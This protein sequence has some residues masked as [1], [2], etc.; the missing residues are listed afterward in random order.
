MWR[1]LGSLNSMEMSKLLYVDQRT[2]LK[3][4]AGQKLSLPTMK[5]ISHKANTLLAI[6]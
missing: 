5:I 2:Y 6:Q 1:Q 3:F 4:E